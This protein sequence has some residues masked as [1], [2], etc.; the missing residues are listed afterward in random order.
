MLSGTLSLASFFTIEAREYTHFVVDAGTR[1][2]LRNLII[3]LA[4][5]IALASLYAFYQKN[6]PGLLVHALLRAEAFTPEAAKTAEELGL[7]KNPFVWFEFKHNTMLKRVVTCIERTTEEGE[8]PLLAYY[9][10][11][12]LKYRA[13]VR[14]EKKG[15]GPIALIITMIAT[16]LL[17]ILLIRLAPA[18]IGIVD[19]MIK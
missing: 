1:T 16:V 7:E 6:V 9:I 15:N 12:E 19:N 4:V 17:A 2:T 5:G 3:A 8:A 13:E 10:P 11:E 14:Y 18:L